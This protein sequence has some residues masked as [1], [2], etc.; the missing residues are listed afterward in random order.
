MSTNKTINSFV[1]ISYISGVTILGTP[2]EIY[3]YGTQYWLIIIP[4]IFMGFTVSTVYLPVFTTLQVGS[5]YEVNDTLEHD[6][7]FEIK[8][9]NFVKFFS[10]QY[11]ELRFSSTVRTIASVMFVIDEVSKKKK[12]HTNCSVFFLQTKNR[13]FSTLIE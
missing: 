7:R 3:S 4:I 13:I 1:D 2:A 10:I 9:T 11:L 12:F 8:M 5:S 6:Y